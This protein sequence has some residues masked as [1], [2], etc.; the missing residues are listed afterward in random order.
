MKLPVRAQLAYAS[1]NFGKSLLWT[2]LEYFL[3]F[4]LTDLAGISPSVA[5]IMIMSSLAW[6]GF[7]N[8][9]VGYWL[10]RRASMGKD[11][12][13]FL[14][15]APPFAA[16]LFV[17]IFIEPGGGEAFTT[18]YLFLIL[19]A[20]RTAYALLDV[21][22]NGLLA[23]LPVDLR[24]RTNLA[25]SRYFFSS[26]AGLL[27]ATV[28][29][30]LVV[31]GNAV[32]AMTELRTLAIIAGVILCMTMWQSLRPARL[33]QAERGRISQPI[34]P[35]H[36][37]AA[38]M[39]SRLAILYLCMAGVF[40][41]TMP[42]FSKML[43]FMARY[44]HE[45]EG[46]LGATLAAM[47]IA[48]MLAVAVFT[49]LAHRFGRLPVGLFCLVAMPVL[50]AVTLA[51]L[52]ALGDAFWLVSPAFGFLL[53]GA[54]MVIWATAG[55]I[56]DQIAIE[57]AVRTDAGLLAFLTLV[58]KAGI[59]VGAMLAGMILE[60][61]HFQAGAIQHADALD[62]ILTLALVLP[63]VGALASA[64]ILCILYRN[65]TRQSRRRC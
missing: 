59:G 36:F 29:A 51:M 26:L 56:A 22:H 44:V 11:Y 50:L 60:S 53:G 9:F 58:Q 3:L 17:G 32:Q 2:S 38:V 21:P 33:G 31:Q 23:L 42:L 16:I 57:A 27:I 49:P 41:I 25:G 14:R 37:L 54:I 13:P 15:W 63:A 39:R 55:D 10:D 47:T 4:Y 35:L 19:F 46:G 34:S 12:R 40:A 52:P 43:P 48:Q 45:N 20:F 5:G 61:G 28:A 8:P 62:A 1:G 6:D 64:V 18:A 30:P 24:T 7:I 65:A